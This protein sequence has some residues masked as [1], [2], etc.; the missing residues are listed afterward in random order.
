VAVKRVRTRNFVGHS[1]YVS[2]VVVPMAWPVVA[3]RKYGQVVFRMSCDDLGSSSHVV[4]CLLARVE[5][6]IARLFLHAAN[7]LCAR[8]AAASVTDA[9]LFGDVFVFLVTTVA[10]GMVRLGLARTTAMLALLDWTALGIDVL[11]FAICRG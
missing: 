5:S 1:G 6:Q 10:L 9:L 7:A 4:Q 8:M 2:R 3:V 11:K